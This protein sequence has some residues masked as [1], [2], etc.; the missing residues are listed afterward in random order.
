MQETLGDSNLAL[1]LARKYFLAANNLGF[2]KILSILQDFA[3]S[4]TILHG[5]ILN[6]LILSIYAIETTPLA[7][8][9]L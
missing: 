1:Y 4:C 3:P 9:Y 5:Y 2:C 6:F 7:M 8:P